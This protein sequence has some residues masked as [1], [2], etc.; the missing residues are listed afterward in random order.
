MQ[1]KP[2]FPNRPPFRGGRPPGPPRPPYK[3]FNKSCPYFE[4][5][6]C[7]FG[8]QCRYLH[9]KK[10]DVSAQDMN[11]SSINYPPHSSGPERTGTESAH[12]EDNLQQRSN[13]FDHIDDS[14][15]PAS[16]D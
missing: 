14:S 7:T 1:N 2:P 3:N 10:S 5:G 16:P 9:I 12:R 13:S 4:Q 8:D 6:R 15:T 11:P